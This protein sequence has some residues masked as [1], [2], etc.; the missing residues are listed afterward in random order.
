MNSTDLILDNKLE[1][2]SWWFK[3]PMVTY[4][5][6]I[7]SIGVPG[8]IIV[9]IIYGRELSKSACDWLILTMSITDAFVCFC[10]PALYIRS[11]LMIPLPWKANF[12]C[13]LEYWLQ[14]TAMF[15]SCLLLAII[16][17]DRYAKICRP[18]LSS[19]TPTMARNVCVIT[20]VISASICLAPFFGGIM[21]SYCYI[22]EIR[23][24]TVTKIFFTSIFGCY[25]V[26]FLI[27]T[28]AYASVC[29]KINQKIKLKQK[30][31]ENNGLNLSAKQENKQEVKTYLFHRINLWHQILKFFPV[32]LNMRRRTQNKN[33]TEGKTSNEF[34]YLNANMA[35]SGDSRYNNA[36]LS[37]VEDYGKTGFRSTD[38]KIDV[39][40]AEIILCDRP[41]NKWHSR[42]ETS[43]DEVTSCSASCKS[44][45]HGSRG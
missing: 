37:Y 9:A 33:Q 30:L 18:G 45:F 6:T 22:S 17:L 14:L 21:D 13:T 40:E 2:F 42:R 15:A 7:S 20:V 24:T 5:L 35:G 34:L 11:C 16:A 10:S 23:E 19:L 8:N 29:Q 3:V 32:K 4:L 26:S 28:F 31:L 44:A 38:V 25:V 36:N 41:D 12:L 39:S 27:V 43:E 1:H